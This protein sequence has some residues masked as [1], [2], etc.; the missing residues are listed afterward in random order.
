M[1]ARRKRP[2]R[3]R[4]SSFIQPKPIRPLGSPLLAALLGTGVLLGFS[5]I[6]AL[7]AIS[8]PKATGFVYIFNYCLIISPLVMI[9][10]AICAGCANFIGTR[11]YGR[12]ILPLVV[13]AFGFIAGAVTAELWDRLACLFQP[14]PFKRIYNRVLD[15]EIICW[16]GVTGVVV[17]IVLAMIVWRIRRPRTLLET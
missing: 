3:R 12:K 4:R 1:R 6:I 9:I 16:A 14:Q 17:Y 8:S 11:K 7:A 2:V 10:C 5:G 15:N 13:A